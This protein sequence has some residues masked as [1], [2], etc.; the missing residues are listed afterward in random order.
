ME[1]HCKNHDHKIENIKNFK[2]HLF[3]KKHN[4]KIYSCCF[5]DFSSNNKYEYRIH[6]NSFHKKLIMNDDYIEKYPFKYN[7]N[8]CDYHSDDLLR[9][10]RHEIT[11]KHILNCNF[12][13]LKKGI[14]PN[15]SII[16]KI[17]TCDYCNFTSTSKYTFRK[18]MRKNHKDMLLSINYIKKYP[19]NYQCKQCDYYT[20][21]LGNYNQHLNTKKHKEK[22][23]IF[24]S[25][26]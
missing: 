5:C 26:S 21:L 19:Y 4:N 13:F 1:Y 16:K 23:D 20:D 11:S 22:I 14:F 3:P 12:I 2:I 9:Y 10:K 24:Y 18:H 15:Y 25:S 17:Y 8:I 6:L 7:C